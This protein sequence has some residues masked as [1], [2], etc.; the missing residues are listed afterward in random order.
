MVLMLFRKK[1]SEANI[2]EAN[3]QKLTFR[4]DCIFFL[5]VFDFLFCKVLIFINDYKLFLFYDF[6]NKC[7]F[8]SITIH[9]IFLAFNILFS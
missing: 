6:F 1:L 7:W 3:M 5:K 8:F 9:L 2:S 4:F